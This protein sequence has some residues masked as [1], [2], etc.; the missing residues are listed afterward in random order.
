MR[1]E[2]IAVAPAG[3]TMWVGGNANGTVV[4]VERR[5]GAHRPGVRRLLRSLSPRDLGGWHDGHRFATPRKAIHV[6]DVATRSVVWRLG[7]LGT[8]RGVTIR[9]GWQDAV[10]TAGAGCGGVVDL[11]GETAGADD[12][13]RG[14]AGWGGLGPPAGGWWPAA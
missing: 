7:S 11:V 5:A 6:A 1:T 3:G 8:G 9:A 2:V 12:W 13:G 14:I 10:G 4:V